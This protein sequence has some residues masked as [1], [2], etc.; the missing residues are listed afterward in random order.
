MV[1]ESLTT[2]F[3]ALADPTRR[4]ILRRLASGPA[5]V[6]D[7]AGPYRISQQAVSKH[8]A[9]LQRARLVIKRRQGR[10]HYCSLRAAPIKQVADW[11][12]D[13]RRQW[14]QKLDRLDAL[15]KELQSKKK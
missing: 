4:S 3:A 1:V 6:N 8:I 12:E 7:L 15:L 10:N 9:Y 5:T 11:S 14:D 2:T 13:Y